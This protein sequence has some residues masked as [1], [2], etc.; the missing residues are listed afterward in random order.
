[1]SRLRHEPFVGIG[2]RIQLEAGPGELDEEGLVVIPDPILVEFGEDGLSLEDVDEAAATNLIASVPGFALVGQPTQR[3]AP[4]PKKGK[5]TPAEEAP[6]SVEPTSEPAPEAVAEREAA[7]EPQA[8]LAP[9]V[10]PPAPDPAPEPTPAE[11]TP[12]AS[13]V[14]ASAA[15][16]PAEAPAA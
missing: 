4:K 11:S 1:M 16:S 6:V 15:E 13:A 5:S 8:E 7:P 3:A 10:E 14:E 12:E 2:G 9:A